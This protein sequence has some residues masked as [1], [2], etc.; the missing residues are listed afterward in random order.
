MGT[1][2]SHQRVFDN[3]VVTGMILAED[4][5]KMSKSK[6]N[7]PDPSTL[8]KQYGGDAFRLYVMNSPVVRSEP[9]RFM[10]K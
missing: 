10:E 8:L 3:C 9:L 6:Q 7:Y 2:V 5:K 1:P 4:G